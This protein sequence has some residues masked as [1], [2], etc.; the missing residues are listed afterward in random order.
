MFC[1]LFKC[2]TGVYSIF[3]HLRFAVST[4]QR[5]PRVSGQNLF[6]ALLSVLCGSCSREEVKKSERRLGQKRI[7]AS[8]CFSY[9][10]EKINRKKVLV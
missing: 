6:R 2:K 4:P 10:Y 3:L 8:P 1:N 5:R 7:N 9:P